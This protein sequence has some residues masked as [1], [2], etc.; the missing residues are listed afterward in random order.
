MGLEHISL[1]DRNDIRSHSSKR[2]LLKL[3]GRAAGF[4]GA[5][6]TSSAGCSCC[7]PGNHVW[8]SGVTVPSGKC[9]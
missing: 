6:G 7:S 1:K 9:Y 2:G 4:I 8:A 3:E 5:A